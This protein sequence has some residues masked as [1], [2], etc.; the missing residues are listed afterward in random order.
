VTNARDKTIWRVIGF[1]LVVLGVFVAA[2]FI[3]IR[4]INKDVAGSDWVNHTHAVIQETEG[5]R[6]DLYIGDGAAHT[7]VLTGDARDR[8]SSLEALSDVSD[9]LEILIALTRN[10]PVQ[11]AEVARIGELA[12]N[13][14]DF[15]RGILKARQAGDSAALRNTLVEDAGQPA[16]KE[17]QS[18]LAKLKNEELA[19]LTDRD[20]ASFV[21]AQTTRW[22][23]WT[24]VILDFLLL[25]G[26][27][28]LI[29]DDL[30]ARRSAAEALQ[31]AN[32]GLEERVR[33][34]TA[35]LAAANDGLKAENLE[36]RW[37]NQ[38][39]EHQLRYNNLI[40]NSIND[41]VLVLTRATNISRVNPA[42]TK[43]TG[44]EPH[45]LIQL[46]L[47][48]LARLV[49]LGE[50]PMLDPIAQAMNEGHDIKDR[51]AV[52]TDRLG[53]EIPVVLALF[54]L[55]DRDKIV[56]AVVI[57]QTVEDRRP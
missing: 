5:L 3:S 8:R 11:Q 9:H 33:G 37:T 20:T 41:L 49:H 16:M 18:A 36:R 46:P 48:S 10:E 2:A 4:N 6:S 51:P 35:E 22:T 28:W 55:R 17:I 40:I 54:P 24:G 31:E 7:F 26:A 32:E 23:V 12:G 14:A 27:G 30:A 47:S 1:F 13:R 50:A 39:L 34:R 45:E 44:R 15:L 43:L 42:V 25:A 56:G 57:I 38:G 19:L 52:I 53:R 21:Q 29:W